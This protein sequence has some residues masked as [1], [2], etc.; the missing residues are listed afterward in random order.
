MSF[1]VRCLVKFGCAGVLALA[2][3]AQGNAQSTGTL[4]GLVVNSVTRQPV[5]R[6]LVVPSGIAGTEPAAMTDASGHFTLSN[7]P[8]GSV[9]LRIRRPGY[10]DPASR[11]E[12]AMRTLA[13]VPGGAE[14]TL[15]LEPAATLEGQVVLPEGE[16][17][18][19][20]RVELLEATVS[21]GPRD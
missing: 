21:R 15:V 2:A 18:S 7:I 3:V 6:V 20:I 14:P 10:L 1:P 5:A 17:P 13:F 11:Q 12:D 4:R 19:G 9:Q 16:P 8:A